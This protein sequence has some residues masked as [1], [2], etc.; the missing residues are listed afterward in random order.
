MFIPR[1]LSRYPSAN[2]T[3]FCDGVMSD[4]A[5]YDVIA[6]LSALK[7]I[8]TKSSKSPLVLYTTAR[9]N[10]RFVADELEAVI[11]AAG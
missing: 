9:G 4:G 1:R 10:I 11:E 8:G 5:G 6:C 2:F 7:V 3:G